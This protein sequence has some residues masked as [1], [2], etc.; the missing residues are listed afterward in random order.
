MATR[1]PYAGVKLRETWRRPGLTQKD[2]A[3]K[4]VISLPYLDQMENNNRPLSTTV[5]RALA[6]GFGFGVT[7]LSTGD[8]ERL[9]SDMRE[10][11]A[12]PMV[13]AAPSPGWGWPIIS[14]ARR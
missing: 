13:G 14:P 10:A 1:K 4:L 2:F 6:Q 5:V 11:L 3:V 7:E 9:V 8:A 12:D